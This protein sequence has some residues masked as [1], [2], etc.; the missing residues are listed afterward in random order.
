[1]PCTKLCVVFREGF[2]VRV[3]FG[4]RE[5][6]KLAGQTHQ[7]LSTP[8]SALKARP[9][10]SLGQRPRLIHIE[11]LGLKAR[12]NLAIM[13][14]NGTGLQPW[15]LFTFKPGALP[16]AGMGRAVGASE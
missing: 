6:T 16:Q 1:R 4:S 15:V 13:R 14:G 3:H 11:E 5:A 10:T 8:F 9:H 12:A 2:G 7:I